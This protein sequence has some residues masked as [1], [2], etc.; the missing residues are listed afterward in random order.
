MLILMMMSNKLVV[1]ISKVFLRARG[2]GKLEK[3]G[4]GGGRFHK[5][6]EHLSISRQRET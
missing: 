1:L 3:E 4:G 5:L 2:E 6:I